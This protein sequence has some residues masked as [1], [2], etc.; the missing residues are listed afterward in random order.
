MLDQFSGAFGVASI[1]AIAG[2]LTPG[3]ARVA[4]AA[5]GRAL[6]GVGRHVLPAETEPCA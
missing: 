4:R 6:I 3:I 2:T 5:A 1:L